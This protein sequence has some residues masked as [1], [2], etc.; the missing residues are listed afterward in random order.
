MHG[1]GRER[2][3]AFL[4]FLLI[5]KMTAKYV[6]YICHLFIV[7]NQFYISVSVFKEDQLFVCLDKNKKKITD[8]SLVLKLDA[9]NPLTLKMNISIS[10]KYY[11][12]NAWLSIL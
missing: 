11:T 2:V 9:V 10:D 3:L 7:V 6:L 12:V 8:T 1:G 5:I 4:L